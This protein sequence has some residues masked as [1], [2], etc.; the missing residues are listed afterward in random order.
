MIGGEREG[1]SIIL[2]GLTK[3]GGELI[4]CEIV[5]I[6][7]VVNGKYILYSDKLTGS[8]EMGIMRSVDSY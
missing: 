6:V 8:G 4:E 3:F 2:T 7:V 5:E 1:D